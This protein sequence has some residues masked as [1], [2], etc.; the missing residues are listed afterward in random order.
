MEKKVGRLIGLQIERRKGEVHG[1]QFRERRKRWR[2]S[3]VEK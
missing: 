3:W 2:R 1:V